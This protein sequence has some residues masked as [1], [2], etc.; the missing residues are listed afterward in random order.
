MHKGETTFY[1]EKDGKLN[2]PIERSLEKSDVLLVVSP[3]AWGKGPLYGVH[4]LHEACRRRGISTQILYLNLLY[5]NITG[6]NVH[7]SIAVDD[8][9]FIGERLFADAAFGHSAVDSCLDKISNMEW[10]PDHI[11]YTKQKV[12]YFRISKEAIL[13]R[14]DFSTINWKLLESETTHWVQL[15]AQRIAN[16]GFRVVGASTS[17][18][19]L[20]PPVALLNCVKKLDPGIITVL[21]GAMCDGDMAKGVLSLKSGIDYVFSGEGEKTFPDFVSEVLADRLPEGKVIYGESITDLDSVP[22][23]DYGE[24]FEQLKK[25]SLAPPFPGS[26]EIPYE[27]SRGCWYGKC[28]FCGFFGKKNFRRQKS[29]DKILNDLKILTGRYGSNVTYIFVDN[30]MPF[31]FLDTLL[32]SLSKEISS[33]NFFTQVNANLTLE[34]VLSLKKA[35]V[36]C[37]GPGIESLSSSLLNQM[38]K[39]VTVRENIA[40]LRYAR[41]VK[42]DIRWNV[43]F[44]FPGEI[45]GVYEEMLRLLPLIRHLQP[46]KWMNSLIIWRYSQYHMFPEMFGISNVKPAEVYKDIFPSYADLENLALYFSGD[47]PAKSYEYPEIIIAMAKEIQAWKRAWA[48]YEIVPLEMMLPTLHITGKTGDEYILEDTRGLPGK[49]E[50]MV[51]GHQQASVLLVPR[52]RDSAADYQWAVDAQ[53]GVLKESWFIPLATADPWLL[54]EFERESGYNQKKKKKTC[55]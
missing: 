43:L 32:P 40:L 38:R 45:A 41:S 25:F 46:P 13:Y 8:F 44:D 4:L 11:R 50:R 24:Y 47:F 20:V 48:A 5:S 3:I 36:N 16:M 9:L 35:G 54:L 37:I 51:L 19:G 53:L 31:P 1:K 14:E 26:I 55:A 15:I 10:A 39:G 27:T 22:L 2:I 12:T 30:S 21:G 42:M 29:P 34:Q 52:P 18:G 23:P 49:P 17:F 28:T 33:I 7:K 6:A